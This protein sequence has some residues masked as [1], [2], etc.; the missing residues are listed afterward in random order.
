MLAIRPPYLAKVSFQLLLSRPT[1]DDEEESSSR[2]TSSSWRRAGTMMAAR[3]LPLPQ[4]ELAPRGHHS[5]VLLTAPSQQLA[6]MPVP[7]PPNEAGGCWKEQ[8]SRASGTLGTRTTAASCGASSRTALGSTGSTSSSG[9]R[10]RAARTRRGCRSVGWQPSLADAGVDFSGLPTDRFVGFDDIDAFELRNAGR[11]E[12]FVFVRQRTLRA[13]GLQRA[14]SGT[15]VVKHTVLLLLHSG[16][17]SLIHNFQ[18]LASRRRLTLGATPSNTGELGEACFRKGRTGPRR[19]RQDCC[20][21]A[22]SIAGCQGSLS[23]C[24]S[25]LPHCPRT[26]S[27]AQNDHWSLPL[28]RQQTWIASLSHHGLTITIPVHRSLRP[29]SK[30]RP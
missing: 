2:T 9:Q 21:L 1:E 10:P 26:K 19:S 11:V 4:V 24:R 22:S 14:P 15:G 23:Q 6:N 18:A 16:H 28:H 8:R 17:F 7:P 3:A 5:G 20:A 25:F 29:L 13:D 30:V 27:F 12:V